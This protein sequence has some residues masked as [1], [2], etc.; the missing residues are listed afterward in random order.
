MPSMNEWAKVINFD[1]EAKPVMME[2]NTPE[3]VVMMIGEELAE[4]KEA[5]DLEQGA[6]EVGSEIGDILYLTLFLCE[7]LGFQPEDLL[8]MKRVRNE[9]K[10]EA[11]RL[12]EG[13]YTEIHQTLKVMESQRW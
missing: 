6:T 3:R 10:Y 9:L 8:A 13:D 11:T 1:V 4:L 7:Q 5:V 12:Q 2:N